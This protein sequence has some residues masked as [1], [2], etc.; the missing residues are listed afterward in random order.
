MAHPAA[1]ST[2]RPV[3]PLRLERSPRLGRVPSR[4]DQRGAAALFVTALLCL[5]MLLAVAFANRNLVVGE[6]ASARAYRSTQAFEAAEAGLAW[7]QAKLNDPA[8]I[9][10][11]CEPSAD[12]HAASARDRWLQIDGVTGAIAPVTWSNAGL[13][14]TLRAACVEAGAGWSCSCPANGAP[15]RPPQAIDATAAAFEIEFFAGSRPGLVRVVAMGC[16]RGDLGC[17]AAA[18]GPN[19]AT[20]R[21]EALLSLLPALRSAPVAALGVRGNVDAG[22]AAI[23]VHHLQADGGRLAMH[24]GGTV[25]ADALRLGVPAGSSLAGALVSGDAELAALSADRFFARHFG[26]DAATWAAQ[27]A[28]RT[29]TCGAAVDCAPAVESAIAAGARLLVVA[30]DAR[31]AGPARFGEADDPVA[32]VVHGNAAISGA[33]AIHGVVA[34]ASMRWDDAAIGEGFVRGTT[35]VGGDYAGSGAPDFTHDGAV[36]ARLMR[37]GSFVRVG[38]SWKDF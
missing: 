5:A 19:D 1:S 26:M 6:V 16:T 18:P 38:G 30:G 37:R 24:A 33:V 31:F 7:A 13:E 21:S 14:T 15:A 10:E 2:P 20:A 4:A 35:L 11:D 36:L 17:A 22:V 23:G 27:P 3:Q 25:V 32:L 28:V 12:V 34:V 29:V 8:R 9:G